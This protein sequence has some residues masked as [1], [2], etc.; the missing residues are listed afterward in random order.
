MFKTANND[1][2]SRPNSRP[3]LPFPRNGKGNLNA[4]GR[5]IWGMYSRESQ[6][7]GIPAHPCRERD[8]VPSKQ[9]MSLWWEQNCGKS[10]N[11]I[12]DQLNTPPVDNSYCT[13]L[14]VIPYSHK[15]VSPRW[16][17]YCGYLPK[18]FTCLKNC[19]LPMNNT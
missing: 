1:G 18:V 9:A 7:T 10:I 11:S 19:S 6:E 15:P 8:R 4:V 12:N 14:M 13:N 5:E 17:G 16:C 2:I 3:K